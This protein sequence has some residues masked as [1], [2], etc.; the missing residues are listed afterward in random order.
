MKWA[1]TGGSWRGTGGGGER[2]VCWI[3]TSPWIT[4]DCTDAP[5]TDPVTAFA[6]D[7]VAGP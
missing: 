1:G 5:V 4:P 3:V 7:T 6:D 2:T